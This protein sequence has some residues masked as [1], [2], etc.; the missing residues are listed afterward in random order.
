MPLG[1]VVL[2]LVLALGQYGG[3]YVLFMHAIPFWEVFR[4]PEKLMGIGSFSAAMLAGAGLDALRAGQGRPWAWVGS[5]II[6][7]GLGL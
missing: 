4:Y 6:F 7:A 3:L 5:A 2:T 1:L